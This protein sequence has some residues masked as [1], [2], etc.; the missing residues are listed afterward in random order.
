METKNAV[1]SVKLLDKE[2]VKV[3]KTTDKFA[4]SRA[5]LKQGAYA[6]AINKETKAYKKQEAQLKRLNKIKSAAL[7]LPGAIG[8]GAAAYA[9]VELVK[10]ADQYTNINS[11]LKLVT[12]SS[13][14]LARVQKELFDISQET[15]TSYL[16]NAGA[17][18]KLG[19]ALESQNVSTQELL[20]IS[21][22]LN[23]SLTVS[24]ASQEE[25]TSFML[26]YT[27]ALSSGV[28]AGEEYRAMTES[29]SYFATQ[30]SDALGVTRGELKQMSKDQKLTTDVLRGAMTKMAGEVA[31]D[32]DGM[33]KTV[34]RAVME[35]RNAFG[36]LVNDTNQ[37]SGATDSLAVNI[38]NFATSINENKTEIIAFF[39]EVLK[40]TGATAEAMLNIGTSFQGWRAV[41]QG[42]ISLL[43]FAGMNPDELDE[44]LAYL[45]TVEGISEKIGRLQSELPNAKLQAVGA[46]GT[47]DVESL[48]GQIAELEKKKAKMMQEELDNALDQIGYAGDVLPASYGELAPTQYDESGGE[49]AMATAVLKFKQEQIEEKKR[50]DLEYAKFQYNL[51]LQE[52]QAARD[53]DA[54]LQSDARALENQELQ[55]AIKLQDEMNRVVIESRTPLEE[56]NAVKERLN[57]LFAEGLDGEAFKRSMTQ[58]TEDYKN[59]MDEIAGLTEDTFGTEVENAIT[60]WASS[61]SGTLTDMV[62]GAEASFGDILE[63]FGKMITEMII[64]EQVIKPLMNSASGDGGWINTAIGAVG[65]AFTTNAD[66]GVYNSPSLSGFSGSVVS[67][68]TT[69]AFANGA[70]IM[71]EAGAEAILP[72]KR[73]SDGKLGVSMDGSGSGEVVVNIYNE[74]NDEKQ[75]TASS[76]MD[77]MRRLVVDVVLSDKAQNGQISRATGGSG[78]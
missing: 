38:S 61:F 6:T 18:S 2:L 78:V 52:L 23:K 70:G 58:A 42:D 68:P 54:Q 29:N 16:K 44:A 75:A 26:Q 7:G 8:A 45:N 10:I 77:D 40:L 13:E 72:L 37:A 39:T 12:D 67:S 73:G 57:F 63:S 33:A 31:R 62:W 55:E 65:N 34:T 43:D 64:M 47:V 4:K 19:L 66:G 46:V 1:K 11:R 56:Y 51:G 30:L 17:L 74:G 60:G 53:L 50:L 48:R 27:Q 15:G 59:A 71:G 41:S 76:E 25:S 69:F 21:E 36:D 5:K 24:G 14:E 9:T 28:L 3:S 35:V 32:F 22:L 49:Q 20:D